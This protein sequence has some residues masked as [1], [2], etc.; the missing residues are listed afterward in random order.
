MVHQFCKNTGSF[1]IGTAPGVSGFIHQRRIPE[2]KLFAAVR[3]TITFD[4]AERQADQPLGVLSRVGN[5]CRTANELRVRPIKFAQA[6]EAA[7]DTGDV[8][9]EHPA[10]RMRLVDNHVFQVAQ[11]TCPVLVIGQDT[12]VKHIRISEDYPGLFPYVSPFLLGS[13]TVKSSQLFLPELVRRQEPAQSAQLVLG[14]GFSGK[15][16]K[17][18]GVFPG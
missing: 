9:A 12:E 16:V 7:E 15:K 8:S 5:G 2:N 18:A 14:E 3:R 13:V 10:I 17:G 11:Q 6:A 1:T 4:D